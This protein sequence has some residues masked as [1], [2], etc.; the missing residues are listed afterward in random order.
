MAGIGFE[1]RK[2]MS[3]SSGLKRS[4]GYFSAAFT[5]FGGML[6]GIVLLSVIQIAASAG[7]K[8]VPATW[9]IDCVAVT[10]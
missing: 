5:C 8:I 9:A 10:R 6:I 2:A 4:G 7:G 3:S 1:L